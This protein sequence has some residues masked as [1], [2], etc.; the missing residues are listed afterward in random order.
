M[1]N[2][3]KNA[4][5]VSDA[6]VKVSVSED[7]RDRFVQ[8]LVE[9]RIMVPQAI[10]GTSGSDIVPLDSVGGTILYIRASLVRQDVVFP[11]FNVVGTT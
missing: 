11:H 3:D 5:R 1:E 6:R 9:T 8:R 7:E 10:A 2:Y 4:W